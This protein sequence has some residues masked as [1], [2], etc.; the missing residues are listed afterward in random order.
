MILT[1]THMK[2]IFAA[3]GGL[4]VDASKMTPNQLHEMVA[5]LPAN[6]VARLTLKNTSSIIPQHLA[7][8]SALAPGQIVFDVSS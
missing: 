7:T 6:H 8:L 3:G 1:M 5:A 2:A 4:V